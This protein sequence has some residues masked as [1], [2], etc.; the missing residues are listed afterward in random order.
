MTLIE[1]ATEKQRALLFYSYLPPWRVDVFNE[2][3]KYYDLTIVFQNAETRGFTYDRELLLQK[4][5]AKSFFW[6]QGFS[7][8]KKVFRT[9]I[10]DL[11]K[12]Y[13]PSVILTH[14]YGPTSVWL[15]LLVKL[16]FTNAQLIVT[17][18]DNVSMIGA[19]G[20]VKRFFRKLI[21]TSTT[22]LVVYSD[23]VKA[24]YES[25]FPKLDVLVCPN[26]QNPETLLANKSQFEDLMPGYRKKY[27]IQGP[28]ILY[29]GR[30]EHI[31][32]LDLLIKAFAKTLSKTHQ[33]VIVGEGSQ[34]ANLKQLTQELNLNDR[35][36]FPGFFSGAA[37]YAWYSSA[38]FFVLPS[39]Y[40]PFGAVVNE[41]MV[42]GC[43]VL[44]SKNIGA[45]DY[46]QQDTNGLVFDP[47]EPKSF[48][49][50]LLKA[51]MLFND[52]FNPNRG[53]L[54]IRSFEKYVG[55]FNLFRKN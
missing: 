21:L 24:A 20:A 43:P 28:Y 18:S 12:E 4:L 39:R 46:I 52:A 6:N 1:S 49:Q 45:L 17:T 54:M 22:R 34:E 37:L 10:S 15:A 55:V 32:G 11:V 35:V 26:I 36:I 51:R 25:M 29:T 2:I 42:F 48:E 9:G 44:A 30:L 40:E 53:N 33:L 7:I 5:Q 16:R 27:S 19:A 14:E 41:A 50:A 23:E 3:G 38:D 31:K 13:A 8:G 47:E